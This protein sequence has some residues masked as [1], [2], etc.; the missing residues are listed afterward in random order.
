MTHT[1]LWVVATIIA[2]IILAG[3][4]LSVPR[5]KDG[6][7][8]PKVP[9]PI[10]SIPAVTVRDV[11]KKGVHTITGS[12]LAPTACTSIEATASLVKDEYILVSISMPKDSGVCLEEATTVSFS[13]TLVTPNTLPIKTTVNGKEASTTEL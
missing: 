9:E 1:R 6:S 2:S 3:F 12:L 7:L 8:P 13:T 5:A 4:A 10:E 11:L